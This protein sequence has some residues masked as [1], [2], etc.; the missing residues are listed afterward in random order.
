MLLRVAMV[1]GNWYIAL[2]DR[3]KEFTYY[4][5]FCLKVSSVLFISGCGHSY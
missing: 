1:G 5:G 4:F 3:I 2:K